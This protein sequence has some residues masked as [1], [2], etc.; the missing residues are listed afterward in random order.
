MSL[1]ELRKVR[2]DD[3]TPPYLRPLLMRNWERMLETGCVL[4]SDVDRPEGHYFGVSYYAMANVVPGRHMIA[5]ATPGW[6]GSDGDTD[7]DSEGRLP[8]HA[9]ALG[10]HLTPRELEVLGLAADG[11]HGP[12]VANELGLSSATTRTHFAPI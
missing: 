2:V 8:P 5:F 3:L 12:G 4:S 6:P 11:L 1:E 7:A 9:S 10:V